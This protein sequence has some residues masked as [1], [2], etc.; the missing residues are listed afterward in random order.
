MGSLREKI[1]SEVDHLP[2]KKLE[3]VLGYLQAIKHNDEGTEEIDVEALAQD[4]DLIRQVEE[5]RKQKA[6]GFGL[7]GQEGLTFLRQRIKE[8]EQ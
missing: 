7:S 5:S 4:G 3:R 8:Y 6:E 2:E 1:K